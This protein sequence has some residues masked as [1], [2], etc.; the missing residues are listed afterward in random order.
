MKNSKDIRTL[1]FLLIIVSV[2]IVLWWKAPNYF[3]IWLP[4]II[5]SVFILYS[6]KH[7][8]LHYSVFKSAVLN[9]IYE[10]ILG[11]FTGTSMNG[12]YVIHLVNHHK[13]NNNSNDWGNTARYQHRSEAI[14]L[15][16][17]ACMTP[18]KFLKAKRKWLQNTAHKSIGLVSKTESW[19]IM[20]V[21]FVMLILKFEAT[22]LY[23]ILPHLLGQLV[24]VSFNY[25]QHAD[26]DPLSEYDHSRNF[27]GKFI[28]FFNFNNGF[29]T[30]HH[31]HPA[32][33][34][35]EYKRIH[36]SMQH[37]IAA[38]LNERNFIYYF[39]R[40][41]LSRN[42]KMTNQKSNEILHKINV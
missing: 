10:N 19:I 26:C 11:V 13:E 39:I 9:R 4:F 24:L 27:T 34:W 15:M 30:A 23:I 1:C 36:L 18:L 20:I 32:A 21:Y 7:N 31:H 16:K 38:S 29:H 17:Y 5:A 25:F 6:I 33:H 35:S 8:H 42:Q 37:K 22:I 14:N 28:N 12:A 3:L 2:R 41:L 40:L